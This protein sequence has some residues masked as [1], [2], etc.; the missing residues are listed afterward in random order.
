MS[1][2]DLLYKANEFRFFTYLNGNDIPYLHNGFK[3]QL[4]YSNKDSIS[5]LADLGIALKENKKLFGHLSYDLKN[6]LENLESNHPDYIEFPEIH[7][8]EPE[9]HFISNSEL[10]SIEIESER[11]ETRK[12]DI[13]ARF[14]KE[15][16]ISIIQRLREHIIEGDCYE[17]NFCMEFYAEN[18]YIDPIYIY[19]KLNILSPM[20]FSALHKI[21]ENYLICASP[22]RFIKKEGDRLISQPIKEQ[23]ERA[24]MKKKTKYFKKNF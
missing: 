15:E 22:E 16:Y 9:H 18:V 23:L 20:P 4:A 2:Q 19:N 12:I 24:Q 14:T 7:F 3:E 5:S 21:D 6:Q 10:P 17:I 13:K 1:L 8:F 11:I